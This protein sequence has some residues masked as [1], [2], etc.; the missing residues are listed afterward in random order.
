[1]VSSR[2]VRCPLRFRG[3]RRHEPGLGC[4]AELL[5]AVIDAD[6]HGNDAADLLASDVERLKCRGHGYSVGDFRRVDDTGGDG[7]VETGAALEQMSP[8]G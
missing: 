6:R 4:D 1:M 3:S 7:S 2:D 5:G 8:C